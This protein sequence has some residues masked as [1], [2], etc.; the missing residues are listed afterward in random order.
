MQISSKSISTAAADAI[1]EMI[2]DGQ[3]ED[4][5]RI[6][7]VHLA[8]ALNISRTPLREG[9]MRLV[10]E[11]VVTTEPRRGFF[12]APLTLEDFQQV[13]EIRPILDPAA[14]Q[15]AGIPVPAEIERLKKL[16]VA[17]M[18]AR[19]PARAIDLDDEWHRTLLAGCPNRVLLGLIDQI[20]GRTRCYEH[21]LFRETDNV[22]NAGDEHDQ[23]IHALENGDLNGACDGL[24]RNMQSGV[25]P[26]VDWLKRRKQ[27]E[28]EHE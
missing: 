6:N 25:G 27:G 18:A 20:I 11:G 28:G 5:T 26:I 4:G 21:A 14:L 7:E 15:L 17:M 19:K 10:A 13:Y 24:K 22:W 8:S 3:L 1:R 9:L 23:I 12:V 16:N 2:V